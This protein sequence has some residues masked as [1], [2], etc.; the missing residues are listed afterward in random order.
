MRSLYFE[1]GIQSS[2]SCVTC[3]LSPRLTFIFTNFRLIGVIN[4]GEGSGQGT[5]VDVLAETPVLVEAIWLGLLLDSGVA[6]VVLDVLLVGVTC[7]AKGVAMSLWLTHSCLTVSATST[8][9]AVVLEGLVF[10]L[11]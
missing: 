8:S 1:V 3:I 10:F 4:W 9:A 2:I 11:F 7:S 5:A 6:I